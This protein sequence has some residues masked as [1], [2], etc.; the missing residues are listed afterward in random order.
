MNCKL[1]FL[2]VF[3]RKL[4]IMNIHYPLIVCLM[5]ILKY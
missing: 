1:N 4:K 3:V 2:T 5:D